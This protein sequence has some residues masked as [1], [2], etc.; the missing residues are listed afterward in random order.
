MALPVGVMEV[1]P[2]IDPFRQ[3]MS[4]INKYMYDI[5]SRFGCANVLLA[6]RGAAPQRKAH[7]RRTY[8]Q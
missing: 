5:D 1:V 3:N 2:M 6:L 4:I 8:S 7:L